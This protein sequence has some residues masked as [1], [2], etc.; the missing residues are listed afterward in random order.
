MHRL[1]AEEVHFHEVGAKDAIIDVA[2]AVA[3]ISA[4]GIEKVTCSALHLGS[5]TVA[6]AHGMLPVP[7]PAELIGGPCL[8]QRGDR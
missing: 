2:G 4:L 5:G 7:A 6:C 1:P 8:F 3:G